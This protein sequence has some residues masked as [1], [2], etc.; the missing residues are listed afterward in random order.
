MEA[1]ALLILKLKFLNTTEQDLN[2]S[3]ASVLLMPSSGNAI[4]L[5]GNKSSQLLC[6]VNTC[7]LFRL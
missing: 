6:S 5:A 3:R 7:C 1:L 2:R 4:E